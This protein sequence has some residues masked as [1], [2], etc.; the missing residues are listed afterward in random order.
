MQTSSVDRNVGRM[1]HWDH[2]FFPFFADEQTLECTTV[3]M[4]RWLGEKQR[5]TR[6]TVPMYVCVYRPGMPTVNSWRERHT[7]VYMYV[8][9]TWRGEKGRRR[10]VMFYWSAPEHSS[11]LN[12]FSG[13]SSPL[14][15]HTTFSLSIPD[16]SE[17]YRKKEKNEMDE[18]VFAFLPL[19]LLSLCI[20]LQAVCIN[21][22]PQCP[23]SQIELGLHE[24]K[25]TKRNR[26]PQI[27]CFTEEWKNSQGF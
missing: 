5:V 6:S 2:S 27:S 13:L 19:P 7:P 24:A 23:P 26:N 10:P 22:F 9:D 16:L 3:C 11:P 8:H 12:L 15:I 14:Y 1:F 17:F 21:W 25:R 18:T 4:H 20:D